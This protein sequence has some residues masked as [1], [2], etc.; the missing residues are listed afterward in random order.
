MTVN[1]SVL[2]ITNPMI[3]N[4]HENNGYLD[5]LKQVGWNI[6]Q[7]YPLTKSE[8]EY[9]IK[10]KNLRLIFTHA[11]YGTRQLPI[12]LINEYGVAVAIKLSPCDQDDTDLNAMQKIDNKL[13]Y[14]HIDESRIDDC[15]P[16]WRKHNFDIL[17]VLPSANTFKSIPLTFIKNIDVC[18]MHTEPDVELKKWIDNIKKRLRVLKLS[19]SVI[20]GP[21]HKMY[22]IINVIGK[23]KLI[24]TLYPAGQY[25]KIKTYDFVS[26][27]CGGTLI[28]NN[29]ISKSILQDHVVVSNTLSH[30]IQ[31]IENMVNAYNCDITNLLNRSSFITTNHSCFDRLI[32]IFTHLKFNDIEDL[33]KSKN[34]LSVKYSWEMESVLNS[35]EE[36]LCTTNAS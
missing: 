6:F 13:M 23:S 4:D 25:N 19:L 35:G 8:I 36:N 33:L 18:I 11:M 22:D 3:P 7:Y 14:S 21:R 17:H 26:I 2:F 30:L 20:D 31:S 15:F 28:T 12:E 5:A 1:K 10:H 32:E 27:M 29:D 16:M 34:R 9:L 24:C